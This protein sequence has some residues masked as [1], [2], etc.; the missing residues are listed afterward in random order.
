MY[1]DITEYISALYS[2]MVIRVF[3]LSSKISIILF[4]I[5]IFIV[6]ILLSLTYSEVGL[7]AEG[8]IVVIIFLD[9]LV[10]IAITFFDILFFDI[11]LIKLLIDEIKNK[12]NRK[13]GT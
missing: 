8:I 7:N 12:Y 1:K 9:I 2:L 5:N 11:Y 4:L 13:N 6:V 10:L 3:K